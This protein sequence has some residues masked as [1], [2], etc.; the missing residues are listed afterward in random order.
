VGAHPSSRAAATL[1]ATALL[2]CA[3]FTPA[4]AASTAQAASA[5]VPAGSGNWGAVA[6][7][8]ITAPYGTG[9]LVLPFPNAGTNGQPSFL[10]QFF[11]VGNTGTMAITAAGY[12]A[13][14]SPASVAFVV[15]SCSAGWDEAANTCSVAPGTV[16]TTAASPQTSS[17]VPTGAGQAIRVRASVTGT[18]PKNTTPSLTVG[19]SVTRAQTRPAT[20]TGS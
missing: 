13:T 18:V 12:T 19:L 20:T 16:L 17:T 5:S 4:Q 10:P 11:T 14:A 9:A 6:T 8:N 15:E 7:T 1:A 2:V 3:S